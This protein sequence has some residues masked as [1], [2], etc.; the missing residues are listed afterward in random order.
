VGVC[1][2]NS[3]ADEYECIP[4]EGDS[5]TM[6]GGC[7]R[8]DYSSALNQCVYTDA[9]GELHYEEPLQVAATYCSASECITY[10]PEDVQTQSAD[11]SSFQD[12]GARD[13]DGNCLG[14]LLV[15]N[16]EANECYL[17]SIETGFQNCCDMD[18][19]QDVPDAVETTQTVSDVYTALNVVWQGYQAYAGATEI[20]SLAS[21]AYEI[22]S[23]SATISSTV[24]SVGS[25]A[26]AGTAGGGAATSSLSS[27]LMASMAALAWAVVI[28][29]VI[30][31]IVSCIVK[32]CPTESLE[33]AAAIAAGRAHFV[34]KYCKKDSFLGCLQRAEVYCT[35]KTKLARILHEQARPQ[36]KHFDENGSWGTATAPYCRGFSPEQFSMI[37]FSSVDLSEYFQSVRTA[38][39]ETLQ[40]SA[41]ENASSYMQSIQ[42]GTWYGP[43]E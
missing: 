23:T 28:A 25:T 27:T 29:V 9:A 3:E 6:F 21:T 11:L 31:V 22:A 32:G 16:G 15:F 10:N 30:Y 37:D 39:L 36:L 8:G 42:G 14:D 33:T 7:T 5:A 19:P 38:T 18:M 1:P 4:V 40:E 2:L 20:V 12:D 26:G 35:Y 24:S 41:V 43:Q 34:G 17:A 13:E